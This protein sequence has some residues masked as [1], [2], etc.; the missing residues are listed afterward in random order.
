MY[1][2][3]G[4][5]TKSW[6][7]LLAICLWFFPALLIGQERSNQRFVPIQNSVSYGI[8]R[9]I[10]VGI[11]DYQCAEIPDLRFAHRDAE[12]LAELLSSG[13]FGVVD[14]HQIKL[15]TNEQAT[16]ASVEAAL[17]WL[18]QTSKPN[19]RVLIYFAGHGDQEETGEQDGFLLC[20]DAVEGQYSTGGT[21]QFSRLRRLCQDWVDRGIAPILVLDA[22]RVG[23]LAGL[24]DGG[25]GTLH[26][27]FSDSMN[28][29]T[30][31]L[32]CGPDEKS[33]EDIAWGNGHGA[34]TW[35][36]LTGMV[37]HADQDGDGAVTFHNLKTFL[38]HE[39]PN[40]TERQQHPHILTLDR[41]WEST[42]VAL[43]NKPQLEQLPSFT[44]AFEMYPD[45]TDRGLEDLIKS[46]PDT[47]I[48]ACWNGFQDAILEGRLIDQDGGMGADDYYQCLIEHHELSRPIQLYIQ[49]TF[50]TALLDD[51]Q[52]ALWSI[53]EADRK[54]ISGGREMI[55]QYCMSPHYFQRAAKIMGTRHRLYTSIRA[56]ESLLSGMLSL[57]ENIQFKDSV[58]IASV[59]NPLMEAIDLDDHLALAWYYRAICEAE[60]M[61]NP[62]AAER[63][64]REANRLAPKWTVPLS[65]MAYMFVSNA[66]KNFKSFPRDTLFHRAV[67]LLTEAFSIRDDQVIT[68]MALG[69]LY[70]YWGD[71]QQA[72]ATYRQVIQMDSTYSL[73]WVGLGAGL[74][75]L[76]SLHAAEKAFSMALTYNPTDAAAWH[77]QGCTNRHLGHLEKARNCFL[78]AIELTPRH[79]SRDS[80]ANLY[81]DLGNLN[82]A[83]HQCMTI[84]S[85]NPEYASA[86]FLLGRIY[87]QSGKLELATTHIEHCLEL[88][89]KFETAI[90]QYPSI[91]QLINDPKEIHNKKQ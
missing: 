2:R 56:R 34:F 83:E 68:W 62:L 77:G 14:D 39:V 48:R 26:R 24:S 71:K 54:V 67:A 78:R 15:L 27:L 61:D 87:L 16:A 6:I 64:A 47:G 50:I 42:L 13:L 60:M 35:L 49:S 74:L 5:D 70:H 25:P 37:G 10:V 82:E 52:Q 4:Y 85:E 90:K 19:E 1:P 80:L 75:D 8:T 79:S 21:V 40:Q 45:L 76:D 28:T 89:P 3:I 41:N 17:D 57:W 88:N 51:G 33:F 66:N 30:R 9:A 29:E 63:S 72:I 53:L 86:H 12:A 91:V 20:F 22:C 65:H 23:R 84:L 11:S 38:E 46:V 69:A 55:S 43:D 32:A 7:G 73:A 81:Y 58:H 31:L 44:S 59:M 18:D 36:L